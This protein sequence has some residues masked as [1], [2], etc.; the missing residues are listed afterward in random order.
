MAC[1]V[2]GKEGPLTPDGVCNKGLCRRMLDHATAA[3]DDLPIVSNIVNMAEW[4]AA[5]QKR[6]NNG[7][8]ANGKGTHQNPPET[9]A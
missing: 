9:A 6:L 2:C 1:I 3:T 5:H 4:K 8:G 7:K